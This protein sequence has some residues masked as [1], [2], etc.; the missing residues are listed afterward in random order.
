M[1]IR[2]VAVGAFQ[3]NAYVL[4]D[5]SKGEAALI[6]PGED[7][8]VLWQTAESVG[9]T[10]RAIWLTHAHVDHV[11]GIAEVRRRAPVPVYLHPADRS[12]YDNA[13]NQALM[14]GLRIEPPPAPDR[15]LAE[16]DVLEVGGLTFTV[17]HVPG[18]SP[19]HVCFHGHGVAF[20]GD[21]L[22]AGS[23]GRTDLPLSSPAALVR[24]L[25]RLLTLPDETIVHPGHG[26]STTIGEERASNPFLNGSVRILERDR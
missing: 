25:K 18:H 21:C 5:E 22:F 19:G 23:I 12:L 17:W 24:S 8:D 10:V 1:I 16:G 20:V 4:V 9:A 2:P 3:E 15:A 6:D 7:G 14:F 26:P 11:G 13:A